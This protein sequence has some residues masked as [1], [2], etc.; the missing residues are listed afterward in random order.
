M[1][2]LRTFTSIVL[3][4]LAFTANAQ[5]GAWNGEL[6]VMG[7]KLPLVFNFTTN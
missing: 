7:T 2:P 5:E 1:K 3:A 6:D 4:M